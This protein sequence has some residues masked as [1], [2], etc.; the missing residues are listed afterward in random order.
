MGGKARNCS[1]LGALVLALVG[2]AGGDRS[3]EKEPAGD[4]Q[5]GANV[6][7]EAGCGSCHTLREAGSTG[8]QGPDLDQRRPGFEQVLRQV[9]N[10]GG[11]MPAFGSSLSR[12][13]LRDVAAFVAESTG[14]GHDGAPMAVEFEPDG[15]KL[16]ACGDDYACL[17]QAYGNLA[18]R[19]GAE[20]ALSRFEKEIQRAGPVE[21]DCHRIAHTI[22]AATLARLEGEVGHAFAAGS[23]VCWSGYYHGVLERA[24][25]DVEE[26]KLGEAA[27]RMCS[28]PG[29]RDGP[30]FTLYQ[31]VHGLGHGLMLHTGYDLPQSLATCDELAGEWEQTSCTGGVFMENLS[32]SY[33]VRSRWLREDDLLYP[34]TTVAERHKL[35]CYL[36]VTSRILPA[37]GFDFA[38]AARVCR[39]SEADWLRTCFQSLGRDA[40]GQTRQDPEEILA[41]CRAAGDL[42]GECVYGAARD[43]A[44]NY[45]GGVEAAVLCE[46]SPATLRARCFEGIG[47]I[48]G[49]LHEGEESRRAACRELTRRY[50]ADCARGAGI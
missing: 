42:M 47:T 45:A 5:A 6:F 43:M 33:G 14:G 22:G 49:S 18:Y 40:S 41:R 27:R 48:L 21:A 11:G 50:L 36:M 28:D 32:S 46:R 19:S 16:G 2:C 37:V 25:A 38:E 39:T 1:L 23:A 17:E 26:N 13:E 8:T 4:T 35:Y 20:A 29:L 10:G 24:L 15:T 44:S 30:T 9:E 7:A 34:C 12:E 31:C 3:E